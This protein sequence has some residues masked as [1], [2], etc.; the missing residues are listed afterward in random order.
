MENEKEFVAL[1]LEHQARDVR[2][3]FVA[4]FDLKWEGKGVIEGTK[5]V[6]PQIPIKQIKL[7]F[8]V[9]GFDEES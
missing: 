2:S 7:N 4:R 8:M 1:F 5:T 6:I 9:R 3:G